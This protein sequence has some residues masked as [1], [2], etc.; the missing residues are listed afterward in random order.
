MYK[1]QYSE[2]E[3][4]VVDGFLDLLNQGYSPKDAVLTLDYLIF[5]KHNHEFFQLSEEEQQEI[6]HMLHSMKLVHV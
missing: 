5:I 4:K 2:P 6:R 1:K 3:R